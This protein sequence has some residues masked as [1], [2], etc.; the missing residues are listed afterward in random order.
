VED[1]LAQPRI[2]FFQIAWIAVHQ[3]NGVRS[4]GCCGFQLLFKESELQ[5]VQGEAVRRGV[6]KSVECD[7]TAVAY[8]ERIMRHGQHRAAIEIEGARMNIVIADRGEPWQTQLVE[9]G[10]HQFVLF[11]PSVQSR[12]PWL[13]GSTA[14]TGWRAARSMLS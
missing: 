9:H 3:E 8:L 1:K 6:R 7:E 2:P 12:A 14:H 13:R 10:S 11:G 4:G 5:F